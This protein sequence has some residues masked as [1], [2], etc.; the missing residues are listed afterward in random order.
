MSD[1]SD[2]SSKW[3]GLAIIVGFF[4]LCFMSRP[5]SSYVR[6]DDDGRLYYSSGDD[7]EYPARFTK[8]GRLL[9]RINS[10]WAEKRTDNIQMPDAY[11]RNQNDIA[12]S[13]GGGW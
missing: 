1:K 9:V 7:K 2:G 3:L 12:E 11:E 4:A 5:P 8:D 6:K 10:K 13:S